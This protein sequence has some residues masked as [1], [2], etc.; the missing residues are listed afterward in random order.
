[1]FYWEEGF[2][3]SSNF[4]PHSLAVI[5]DTACLEESY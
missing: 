3:I 1:M 5:L 4:F 2:I